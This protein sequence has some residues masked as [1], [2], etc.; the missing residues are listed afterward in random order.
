MKSRTLV[1]AAVLSFLGTVG[2]AAWLK[3]EASRAE[4]AAWAEVTDPV[5]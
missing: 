1:F 2:Y 4:R 5:D 3:L